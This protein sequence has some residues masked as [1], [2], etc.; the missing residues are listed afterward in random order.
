MRAGGEPEPVTAH[1]VGN[2]P[3][4]EDGLMVLI[5]CDTSATG[6]LVAA[7]S[8]GS[9]DERLDAYGSATSVRVVTPDSVAVDRDNETHL[10]EMRPRA[11]L[12]SADLPQVE[13]ADREWTSH[14]R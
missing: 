8:A 2:D 4:Q 3:W 11:A 12:A 9:W 1:A 5:R 6:A 10:V 14:A 7:R 13:S